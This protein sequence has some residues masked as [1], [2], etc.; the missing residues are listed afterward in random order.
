VKRVP[1]HRCKGTGR[2]K[3]YGACHLC[4]GTGYAIASG[5]SEEV[6][7]RVA[8]FA[9]NHDPE[10]CWLLQGNERSF[11]IAVRLLADLRATGSMPE[12]RLRLIR[13]LMSR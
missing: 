7:R 12:K 4:G 2:F 5:R 11:R 3:D 10:F 1:C 6:R 8:E 13:R 9:I